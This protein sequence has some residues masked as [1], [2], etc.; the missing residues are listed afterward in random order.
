MSTTQHYS[1]ASC[2]LANVSSESDA[3]SLLTD[4]LGN[5]PDEIPDGLSQDGT[6]ADLA[7]E[8]CPYIG[9]EGNGLVTVTLDTE[10]EHGN[11]HSEV[12]EF[13]TSHFAS[14]QTSPYMTVHWANYD[15]RSGMSSGTTYYDRDYNPIEVD[16]AVA[17]SHAMN[18]I[19]SLLSGSE[20]RADLTLQIAE[21][22]RG[23]GRE[24]SDL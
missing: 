5:H 20:W 1:S 16:D 15:S 14:I 2:T 3:I 19:A 8:L 24:V 12:F 10:G 23:T 11:Y 21:I 9:V 7:D 17:D 13:I 18:R 4:W 22:V 6:E